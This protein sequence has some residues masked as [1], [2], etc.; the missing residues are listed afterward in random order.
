MESLYVDKV[1]GI[2]TDEMFI[3]FRKKIYRRKKIIIS[4][5]KKKQRKKLQPLI[6]K[7]NAKDRWKKTLLRYTNVNKLTH[8]MVRELIDFIEIGEEM[9]KAKE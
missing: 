8:N 4:K 7:N 9:M 3:D 5:E 1:R 6:E 2:I